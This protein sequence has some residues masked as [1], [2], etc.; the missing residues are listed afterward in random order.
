MPWTADTWS[1]VY[2]N[3][4]LKEAGIE[5]KPRTWEEVLKVSR[6]I[7]KETGKIRFS[8]LG[9]DGGSFFINYYLWSN[10]STI[11]DDDG[12]GG[13]KIGVSE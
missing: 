13:F 8:F 3:N 1:M 9:G 6:K 11:V 7:K 5:I 12:N 4:V 2:N 10:G